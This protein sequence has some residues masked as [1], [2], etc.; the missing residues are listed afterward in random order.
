MRKCSNKGK[1]SDRTPGIE[2]SSG[3]VFIDLGY[4][5]AK[6][7]NIVARLQLMMQIENIIIE[8]GWTQEQAAKMLGLRQPRVSEL[9][10]SRSEKFTVDMLMKLLHRLGKKVVLTVENET[11]V[12]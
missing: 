9:M 6:A 1:N 7:V 11:D 3:N 2:R 8:Q 10:S 12:A 4:P 5:E